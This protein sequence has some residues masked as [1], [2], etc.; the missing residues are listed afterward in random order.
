MLDRITA[1][2]DVVALTVFFFKQPGMRS[3]R[4]GTSDVAG[5]FMVL[6]APRRFK[7]HLYRR[8]GR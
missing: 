3:T 2:I 8:M 7:I 5:L 4:F 6:A 1:H